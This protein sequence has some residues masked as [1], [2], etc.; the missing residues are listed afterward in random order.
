[1]SNALKEI[2]AVLFI[3]FLLVKDVCGYPPALCRRE[4]LLGAGETKGCLIVGEKGFPECDSWVEV[5]LCGIRGTIHATPGG[6]LLTTIHPT[7]DVIL[8]LILLI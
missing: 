6:S 1:M 7:A 4:T 3:T 5:S 8:V 2:K